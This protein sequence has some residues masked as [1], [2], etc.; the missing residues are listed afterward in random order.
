MRKKYNKSV[1]LYVTII[2]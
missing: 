1:E 2:S